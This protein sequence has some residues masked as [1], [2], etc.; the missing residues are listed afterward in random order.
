MTQGMSS[1]LYGRPIPS[2]LRYE[3]VFQFR[4]GI[5]VRRR[6]GE[7]ERDARLRVIRLDTASA[8]R[9]GKTNLGAG[10]AHCPCRETSSVSR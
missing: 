5:A 10:L 1:I 7:I 8:E 3:T 6:W 9:F 4:T 2:I